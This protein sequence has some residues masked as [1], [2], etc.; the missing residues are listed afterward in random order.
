MFEESVL[1]GYHTILVDKGTSAFSE[2]IYHLQW[3]KCPRKIF[4][5][6]CLKIFG[7]NC[8]LTK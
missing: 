8:P 3:S 5:L 6:H 4:L 7:S 2:K 1:L